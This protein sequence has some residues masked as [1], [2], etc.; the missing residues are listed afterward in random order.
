[1]NYA[2]TATTVVQVTLAHRPTRLPTTHKRGAGPLRG[3]PHMSILENANV[4][5]TSAPSV[6]LFSIVGRLAMTQ[7][8]AHFPKD[9]KWNGTFNC[10]IYV[11][12][13][14]PLFPYI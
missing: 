4:S 10:V 1:M 6:E 2:D 8:W 11:T 7:L 14:L 13:E 12:Q 3:N 9:H 5:L